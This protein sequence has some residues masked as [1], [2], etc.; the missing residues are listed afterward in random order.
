MA[1]SLR[2]EVFNA[3]LSLAGVTLD[4]TALGSSGVQ[5]RARAFQS[6]VGGGMDLERAAALSGLLIEDD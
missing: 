4:F 1:R 3:V 5:A 6:M 2:A